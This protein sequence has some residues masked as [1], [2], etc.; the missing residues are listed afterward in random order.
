MAEHIGAGLRENKAEKE[1]RCV[2][3]ELSD[4]CHIYLKSSWETINLSIVVLD[5]VHAW[6]RTG[7][8]ASQLLCLVTYR[9]LPALCETVLSLV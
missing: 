2:N 6:S 9:W 4:G 7:I 1:T 5:G 3:L 8:Y